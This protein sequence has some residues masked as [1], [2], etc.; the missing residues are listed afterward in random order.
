M[1]FGRF[2]TSRAL[3]E[4]MQKKPV[5]DRHT[6]LKFELAMKLKSISETCEVRA[7]IKPLQKGPRVHIWF[8]EDDYHAV[9]MF[10]LVRHDMKDEHK[11]RAWK[12]YLK[13]YA[14]L[15]SVIRSK[16]AHEAFC[17]LFTD[18]PEYKSGDYDL[19]RDGMWVNLLS[20][21]DG[22]NYECYIRHIS[23][24][25][26]ISLETDTTHKNG[27]F[28]KPHRCTEC[29]RP[30]R[31]RGKCMPC[32]ILA[33]RE[34]EA[35]SDANNYNDEE[36]VPESETDGITDFH[37]WDYFKVD[38]IIGL[39]TMNILSAVED[40][41]TGAGGPIELD[42]SVI[43]ERLSIAEVEKHAREIWTWPEAPEITNVYVAKII[44]PGRFRFERSW[45]TN[46]DCQ[47]V[48]ALNL[49]VGDTVEVG[50]TYTG[51]PGGA[52]DEACRT[53]YVVLDIISGNRVFYQ[54]AE[55]NVKARRSC[56]KKKPQIDS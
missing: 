22:F 53:Y 28:E 23:S 15:I 14:S 24:L 6:T 49:D 32:N 55:R 40:M 4:I 51:I 44:G 7:D 8:S 2:L 31:H 12:N 5:P 37:I 34:R 9:I 41:I 36:N 54:I 10:R 50:W 33:K 21:K 52:S 39:E 43:K 19:P 11:L 38:E 16:R 1:E 42:D 18:D 3:S 45:L 30:I 48:S 26:D 20:S 25:T 47:V 35:Q 17:L 46:E 29:G 27:E 13:D 56:K